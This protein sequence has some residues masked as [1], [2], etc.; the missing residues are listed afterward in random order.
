MFLKSIEEITEDDLVQLIENKVFEKRTMEYKECFPRNSDKDKKEFLADVSSFANAGGG[1][2]LFGISSTNGIPVQIIGFDEN[3]IDQEKTRLENII[4]DCIA[5]RLTSINIHTIR[6]RDKKVIM[7][8]RIYKS[9][10]SPHWVTYNNH[11]KFYMRNNS[12]KYPMDVS[13]LRIAFNLSETLIEKIKRFRDERLSRILNNESP[14]FLNNNA[15]VALHLIPLISFAPGQYY[16]LR[17]AHTN[18]DFLKPMHSIGYIPRYNIDGLLVYDINK[19][20]GLASYTQFFNNGVIEAVEGEYSYNEMYDEKIIYIP[21]YENVIIEAL[22]KYINFMKNMD[23]APS[24]IIFTNFINVRG[25]KFSNG[26]K[27]IR[28]EEEIIDRDI[29]ILPEALI[30]NYEVNVE[31]ILKNTF[32]TLWNVIDYPGSPNY[33]EEGNRI[34]FP[35]E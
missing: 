23:I 6:L 35:Q 18:I 25:Y 26:N 9:W 31:N 13:E 19:K 29:I 1:D 27:H 10:N 15:K 3:I 5:P 22:T 16:D 7:I 12:G 4:R 11:N 34:E 2:L 8:I 21:N 32:D 30:E 14:I 17:K 28:K 20:R 24:F 33:N